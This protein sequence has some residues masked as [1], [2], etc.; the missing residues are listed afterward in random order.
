MC[1][2]AKSVDTKDVE[3]VPDNWTY[4]DSD[5]VH[6]FWPPYKNAQKFLKAV[7]GKA[8]YCST[9]PVF[10]TEVLYQNGKLNKLI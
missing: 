6:C 2:V 10:N 4:S 5:G 7:K 9:W 1:L 3:V 8:P